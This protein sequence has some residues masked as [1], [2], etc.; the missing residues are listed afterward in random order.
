M[1]YVRVLV[2]VLLVVIAGCPGQSASPERTNGTSSVVEGDQVV[3]DHEGAII[4]AVQSDQYDVEMADRFTIEAVSRW[5]GSEERD[6]T[7]PVRVRPNASD[8]D[9]IVR[10]E[11]RITTC[12]NE[13]TDGTF[14]YC[15]QT[16]RPGT[17]RIA[18]SYSDDSVRALASVAI[19]G[20]LGVDDPWDQSDVDRS[21][22]TYDDP[23]LEPEPV[24]VRIND[25]ADQP[26]RFVSLVNQSLRYWERNDDIYGT[27]TTT[28]TLR[29]DAP[30]ADVEVRFVDEIATCDET[31]S[32]DVIGCAPV[33]NASVYEPNTTVVRIERGY[34]NETTLTTLKHEFGHV[35]GLRHG[36]EPMPLMN[37][38]NVNA[39]RLPQLNASQRENPWGRETLS[40]YVDYDSFRASDD[41]IRHQVTH[42][43]D[44]YR[45]G[46][47]GDAPAGIRFEMT[48][49]NET[50]N[51]SINGGQNPCRSGD[52]G[53]C[54]I[55]LGSDVDA[56]AALEKYAR[57]VIYL[58]GIDD[59]AVGWHVGYWMGFSVA[60]ATEA[61]ELPPPFRDAE[62]DDRRNWYR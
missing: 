35:F 42:A 13:S 51:I 40:V 9:V 14:Y 27:Y 49:S 10:Y 22:I 15:W 30:S 11:P 20:F 50:A 33:Y 5:E 54:A 39:T 3:S 24:T 44:Y 52:D 38:T 57:Q 12:N 21:E 61:S 32:D 41:E 6:E 53:S 48:A 23:W 55:T 46:A 59:E 8:P 25:S 18:T 47:D 28:F 7:T 1:G 34:T 29:P 31:D 58:Q 37:E 17:I 62:Y 56:D 36:M 45:D 2:A 19:G 60:G 43:L 16:G 26:R 4:V